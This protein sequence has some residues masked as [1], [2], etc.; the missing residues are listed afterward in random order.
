MTNS[1]NIRDALAG[2]I[3]L[4]LAGTGLYLN[5]ANPIGTAGRMGPGYMPMVVFICLGVLGGGV[6]A[7]ALR[8]EPERL[9]RIAWR[10]LGLIIVALVLFGALLEDFGMALATITLTVISGLAD[11]EQTFRGIVTM[12]AFLV[13]ACWLVFVWGLNINVPF[14]PPL[15]SGA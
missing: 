10:E 8:G 11:R 13:A 14:L 4:V 7:V 3:L 2:I 1:M 12:T 15:I 9:D 5:M 6:V